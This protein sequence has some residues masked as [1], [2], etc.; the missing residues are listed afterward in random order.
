MFV[1]VYTSFCSYF[2]VIF[3]C[4]FFKLFQMLSIY[5]VEAHIVYT[6]VAKDYYI[7]NNERI[8]LVN[9]DIH[10]YTK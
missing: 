6:H 4:F 8:Q 2:N 5:N 10:K 9:I 3:L 7:M 1:F